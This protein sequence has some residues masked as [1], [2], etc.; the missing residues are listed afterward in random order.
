MCK[1]ILIIAGIVHELIGQ[2]TP[3]ASRQ[4]LDALMDATG[5]VVRN[6][7]VR[8]GKMARV[9]GEPGLVDGLQAQGVATA[10]VAR[11]DD[12]GGNGLES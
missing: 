1:H 10:S 2:I 6:R 12:A 4:G 9:E 11:M 7:I 3:V 5:G 8:R